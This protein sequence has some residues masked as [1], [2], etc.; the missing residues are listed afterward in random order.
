[1]ASSICRVPSL[2]KVATIRLPCKVLTSIGI[3]IVDI[4]SFHH[5]IFPFPIF[6]FWTL[7]WVEHGTVH[8]AR[9][10]PLAVAD[11]VSTTLEPFAF[12]RI[13]VHGCGPGGGSK[14]WCSS[15]QPTEHNPMYPI[16]G[17]RAPLHAMSNHPGAPSSDEAD[18][19]ASARKEA[20]GPWQAQEIKSVCSPIL[21][22]V[23][24]FQKGL[25]LTLHRLA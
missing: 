6:W 20:L 5:P 10:G 21:A 17:R 4:L 22:H 11:M 2:V 7:V 19:K 13:I 1:M 12:S 9:K 14:H 16:A 25:S 18:A 8:G 15:Q 3:S 24:T 23:G